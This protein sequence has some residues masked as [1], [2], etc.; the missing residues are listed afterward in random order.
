[1]AINI[2]NIIA[3][4]EAKVAAAT[5]ATE[6][7]ELIVI[8][9]SIKA[10][11]QQTVVTY[12]DV[13]N[14]PAANADNAGNL[15]YV[16]SVGKIYYSNGTT[17]TEVGSG[18]G[19]G[20]GTAYDQDLNTTD[21]VV[22]N[23][24]LV[25][26]VSIIGNEISSTDAYGNN[27]ALVVAGDL[28]VKHSN[29]SL[30]NISAVD[31]SVGGQYTSF[32]VGTPF[33]PSS[34]SDLLL[35][36]NP[37]DEISV[38]FIDNEY[39]VTRTATMVINRVIQQGSQI[40]VEAF[41]DAVTYTQNPP[42]PGA[43]FPG[44][45]LS[46]FILTV[47]SSITPLSVT[48]SGVNVD[49]TFT[50]NGQPVSGGGFDGGSLVATDALI[51][52]VSI[53]GN[54]ISGVDA[55][56]NN[57]ELLINAPL[58]VN[59]GG[60]SSSTVLYTDILTSAGFTVHN[61]GSSTIYFFEVRQA[62]KELLTALNPGDT[63][64]LRD[65]NTNLPVTYTFVSW[66]GSGSELFIT[67]EEYNSGSDINFGQYY[68]ELNYNVDTSVSVLEVT[69]S[70][71]NVNGALTVNGQP[72]SGGSGF[73]GGSLVATDALIGDVSIAG[74]EISAV[75]SYGNDA[76]LVVAAPVDFNFTGTTTSV[77]QTQISMGGVG[78]QVGMSG[79]QIYNLYGNYQSEAMQIDNLP[80]GTV[81]T[82]GDMFSFS[83][84]QN[85]RFRFAIDSVMLTPDMYNPSVISNVYID[86]IGQQVEYSTDGGQS[87][88]TTSIYSYNF[89]RSNINL[90]L[91]FE[92]QVTTNVTQTAVS[93]T[94]SG[95]NVNGALTV[96]GQP[97]GAGGSG[98]SYDQSLN[99]TDDVV[100]N[101]ALIGDVTIVGN[102]ISGTDGY[103]NPNTLVLNSPVE[104]KNTA[105]TTVTN[106]LQFG[107]S[108]ATY[109]MF[110]I[111]L[112]IQ[113][114]PTYVKQNA[115][116]LD[117][118]PV[119]TQIEVEFYDYGIYS[120]VRFRF[121]LNNVILSYDPYNPSNLSY[122]ILYPQGSV[123]YST[124]GGTSW[125]MSSGTEYFSGNT[126]SVEYS[127]SSTITQTVA[128]VTES[129]LNVSNIN[130][131]TDLA[132]GVN[133]LTTSTTTLNM[134]G[135][136]SGA[137]MWVRDNTNFKYYFLINSSVY[138]QFGQYFN[139]GTVVTGFF[140][141]AGK[142]G[143]FTLTLVGNASLRDIGANQGYAIET[144]QTAPSTMIDIWAP[145]ITVANATGSSVTYTFDDQGAFT[146]PNV[147]A[148]TALIGD[149]SVVANTISAVDSYGN[150]DTLIVDGSL[151]VTKNEIMTNSYDSND[152]LTWGTVY[153]SS[154]AGALRIESYGG[155]NVFTQ[156]LLSSIP[157][158]ARVTIRTQSGLLRTYTAINVT[159][160]P[161]MGGD[162]YLIAVEEP[163]TTN[164]GPYDTFIAI[165]T[166]SSAT[167]LSVTE[168]GVNV[169][170]TLTING[171]PMGESQPVGL[172]QIFLD[173]TNVLGMISVSEVKSAL[174]ISTDPNYTG[175]DAVSIVLPTGLSGQRITIFNGSAN[176]TCAILNA[177]AIG[178]SASS[179]TQ[180]AP[181][182]TLNLVHVGAGNWY[183]C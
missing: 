125:N 161:S 49:G 182:S 99:T 68:L 50:V 52:D 1:M 82:T 40:I 44:S 27:T 109:G 66:T 95:L 72:I 176:N 11:G 175:S 177:Y 151:E 62:V 104:F 160:E 87:W 171:Q 93:V 183:V 154:S 73:D 148:E 17:W 13:P 117:A 7:Q 85:V 138:S 41:N 14:L 149:V 80:Q 172:T 150:S 19:G 4:L 100:F 48:A 136:G 168:S 106:T 146:T 114:Q 96:N 131:S 137:L 32:T 15:A 22:F 89:G 162:A 67:V 113:N 180:I 21:D 134:G 71:I 124:N 90:D 116:A 35:G 12:A 51:G 61:S 141:E 118:L 25:G 135:S 31:Y 122:V 159:T 20:S 147:I 43:Y 74:N 79:L 129:G 178:A 57:S 88:T 130:S 145:E 98:S 23:S 128:S 26:D 107:S 33:N 81:I 165:E 6:T 167:P 94:E 166:T 139:D 173:S 91:S 56:G 39:P 70:G 119:G 126:T 76:T 123:E 69:E 111:S 120:N 58:T 30:Y 36:L 83:T 132:I 158:G 75:D 179:T 140:N 170:G 164:E 3:A 54:E 153:P 142:A 2:Q 105:N 65:N 38:S 169:N 174:F 18:S 157:T 152:G 16:A 28:N 155:M 103:G 60:T 45:F 47:G 181:L 59:A 53:I 115:L 42:S 37:S 102:E 108:G 64:T 78:F 5:S 127:A 10:A 121:A 9:K 97:V 63:F 77:V 55:Y 24:A 133:T 8:I 29:Q 84:Y 156:N 101:S 163:T 46:D 92:A 144:L 86:T 112:N 110:S 34:I 143:P